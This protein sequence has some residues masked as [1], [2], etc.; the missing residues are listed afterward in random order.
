MPTICPALSGFVSEHFNAL[1]DAPPGTLFG[2]LDTHAW[3]SEMNVVVRADG[4]LAT[5]ALSINSEC[6]D[7]LI[8]CLDMVIRD[9][10]G[11]KSRVLIP[12]GSD[13]EMRQAMAEALR[14]HGFTT[15]RL[16]KPYVR[17]FQAHIRY[18]INRL[19][20]GESQAI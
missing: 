9:D 11:L 13:G 15:Y 19:R 4:L 6:N 8:V 5:L 10:N 2:Y 1:H 17:E 3:A 20:I 14:E 18:L 7:L 16:E 12:F